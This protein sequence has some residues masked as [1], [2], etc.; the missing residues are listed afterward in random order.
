[1]FFGNDSYYGVFCCWNILKKAKRKGEKQYSC[2][3][4][5]DTRLLASDCCRSKFCLSQSSKE[6]RKKEKEKE[7]A[8]K[9][10]MRKAKEND[11][12]QIKQTCRKIPHLEEITEFFC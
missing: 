8:K 7:K 2:Q 6:R 12:R 11:T 5:K 9:K 4:R 3:A 1:M 10:K